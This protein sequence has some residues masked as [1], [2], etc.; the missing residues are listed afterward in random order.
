[1]IPAIS[2]HFILRARERAPWLL[3]LED[4]HFVLQQTKEITNTR[5]IYSKIKYVGRQ[6]KYLLTPRLSP[7]KKQMVI[8]TSEGK[9][10][11][12][13]RAADCEWLNEALKDA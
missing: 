7:K 10:I 11:T 6:T 2:S 13:Y 12:V 9:L 5:S 8:V 1:M 4:L 3:Q